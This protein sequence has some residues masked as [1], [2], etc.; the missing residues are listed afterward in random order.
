MCNGDN[1]DNSAPPLDTPFFQSSAS[2]CIYKM[3]LD[4]CM[5]TW[6]VLS[7]ISAQAHSFIILDV[8]AVLLQS[9]TARDKCR[10]ALRG[11]LTLQHTLRRTGV[12]LWQ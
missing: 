3:A 4:W 6:M 5:A 11:R 12:G 9:Q 2:N 7:T 1:N 10:V 8:L